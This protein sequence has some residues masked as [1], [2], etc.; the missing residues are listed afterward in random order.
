MKRASAAEIEAF[1][2]SP[3]PRARLVLLHGADAGLVRERAERA[4]LAVVPALDDPFRVVKLAAADL[5]ADPARLGDEAAAIAMGGGRRVVRV[6]E[7][8]DRL[9]K[10]I[11]RFLDDP[12]GDALIVVEAEQL[13]ASSS[14][15]KTVEA[16]ANA[17]AIPCYPDEG[18]TLERVISASLAKHGL[19]ADEAARAYLVEHLGG[20]RLV[21]RSELEKLALYAA[22]P[23]RDRAGPITREEAAASVGDTAALT[24]DDLV[25][26]I[27]AGDR[28]KTD[29]CLERLRLEGESAVALLRIVGRHL[30]R[31]HQF[32]ALTAEGRPAM[33]AARSLRLF[34]PR[35]AAFIAAARTW[36]GAAL[37]DAFRRLNEA[38]AQCKSTGFPDWLVA[39]RALAGLAGAVRATR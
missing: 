24:Y 21:T 32:Q 3:D 25:D 36:R 38:E 14:L 22:E 11:A 13:P 18:G 9:T 17:V 6:V 10:T 27:A 19:A 29:R 4:T 5:V 31:F 7:A 23:D 1:L 15:R 16:S 34:G 35:A 8:G 20:D 12:L 39:A 28:A 30:Q 2:K 26:A 33:D 37:S